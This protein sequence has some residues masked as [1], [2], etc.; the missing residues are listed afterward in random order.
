[1]AKAAGIDCAL[2]GHAGN[3]IVTGYILDYTPV[4]AGPV[5]DLIG[6]FTD[7]TGKYEGNLII[8]SSPRDLKEKVRVWGRSR[9]DEVV[10]RRL[11]KTMDP[12]GVLNAGR[13]VGGI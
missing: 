7:E 3:G 10:M 11:K 9:S 2:I 8:E 1:M 13:F 6:K 12:A 4:N 5:A